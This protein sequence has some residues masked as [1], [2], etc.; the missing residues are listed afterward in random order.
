MSERRRRWLI[1]L[2]VALLGVV[3][4]LLVVWNDVRR[5]QSALHEQFTADVTVIENEITDAFTLYQ[6]GLRGARGAVIVAGVDDITA[7][8]FKTYSASRDIE[9]EFPGA[10]G[11]GFIRLCG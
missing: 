7:E 3:V 4:T 1:V 8:Q 11:F 10:R 9:T 2:L 5:A 6:Y